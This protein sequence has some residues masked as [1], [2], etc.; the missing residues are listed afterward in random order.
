MYLWFQQKYLL[1]RCLYGCWTIGL[2]YYLSSWFLTHTCCQNCWNIVNIGL[3]SIWKI[4][5]AHSVILFYVQQAF[6]FENV[7]PFPFKG[8]FLRYRVKWKLGI[9][10]AV[11]HTRRNTTI[12]PSTRAGFFHAFSSR[13]CMLWSTLWST[14]YFI[15]Y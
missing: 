12:F 8:F 5:W 1:N 13:D 4:S 7:M 9:L 11:I 15:S 14:Y 6:R 3:F 10:H 2:P